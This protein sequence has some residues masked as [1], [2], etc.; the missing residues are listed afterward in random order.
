MI[1]ENQYST[2]VEALNALRDRGYTHSFHIEK[3][4]AKCLETQ[5][6]YTPKDMTIIEYH[7]FEGESSGGDMSI[8]YAVECSDGLKGS[9]VDAY[10]TY[11][12]ADTSN[13]LKNVPIQ[14]DSN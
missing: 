1:D 13:F 12:A 5:N 11:S 14:D 6:S 9:I 2:M 10:G 7:R 8:V 4:I 3:E